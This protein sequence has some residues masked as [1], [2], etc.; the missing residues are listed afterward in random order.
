MKARIDAVLIAKAGSG[1]ELNRGF[2]L[3]GGLLYDVVRE[4]SALERSKNICNAR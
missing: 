2:L 1:S 4:D 3:R